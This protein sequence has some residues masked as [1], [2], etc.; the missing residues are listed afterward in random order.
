MDLGLKG[1]KA[2]VTGGS[3][4]IGRAICLALAADGASVA[5]CARGQETL[6]SALGEIRAHGVTAYGEALD[7]R[8]EA[9]M[10]NW[11]GKSVEALGG[12]DIVI[13]NVST[14]IPQDSPNWWS[15]TF[16][17][18]LMQH[19]R[20]MALAQPELEKSDTGSILFIA[21]IA[22]VYTA[23]PPM[24]EAYGAMKA[25]LVNL[26]GQWAGRLAHKGIRVNAISPGPI[27]FPGGFW[28]NVGKANPAMLERAAQ[29]PAM[30][31]LGTDT[32][33]A[34]A[35]VFLASPAASYVTGTNFRIDGGAI[36]AANF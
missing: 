20:L 6:D 2:I 28:D 23:L 1:K 36:K 4:G 29:L 35:A 8:D 16:E 27:L 31:R 18:D 10:A 19:V 34:N 33:V 5:T 25:G 3:R 12:V 13:S 7:V 11:F 17:V 24:E 15:E 21:S 22:S 9:A 30:G 32:E 26:V 14:R